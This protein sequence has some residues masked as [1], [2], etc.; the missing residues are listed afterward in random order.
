MRVPR[1]FQDTRL[2]ERLEISLNETASRY[3]STVLRLEKDSKLILFNGDGKEYPSHI[4]RVFRH[5]VTV[6]IES[7]I[8]KNCESPLCIHLRSI[9]S[10]CETL[11]QPWPWSPT[12]SSYT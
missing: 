6:K 8:E 4:L 5:T 2:A 9:H 12:G 3:L 1:I 11:A 10:T 7:A